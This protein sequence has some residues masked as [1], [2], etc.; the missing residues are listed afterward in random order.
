MNGKGSRP[1]KKS[2]DEAT[3]ENNW[4]R[5]FRKDQSTRIEIDLGNEKKSSGYIVRRINADSYEVWCD[6]QQKTLFLCRGEFK[7][8]D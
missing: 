5:I 2:V 6:E 3:W 7:E 1:R 4:N 8:A